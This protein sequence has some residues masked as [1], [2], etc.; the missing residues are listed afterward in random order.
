MSL[1]SHVTAIHVK[2]NQCHCSA[3]L[4]D[5]LSGG[6]VLE[7][8]LRDDLAALAGRVVRVQPWRD[9]QP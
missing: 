1:M 4:Y 5:P 6:A 9:A 8:E 3:N 2:S 7:G